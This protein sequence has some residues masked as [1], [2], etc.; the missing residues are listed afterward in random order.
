MKHSADLL[1]VTNQYLG[2]PLADD[3]NSLTEFELTLELGTRRVSGPEMLHIEGR[4]VARETFG[5]VRRHR[6]RRL[7]DLITQ[8]RLLVSREALRNIVASHGQVHRLLPDV[9]ITE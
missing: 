4:R 9:E 1:G 2:F 8:N 5:H 3:S 7:T 6:E